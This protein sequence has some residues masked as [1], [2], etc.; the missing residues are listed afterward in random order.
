MGGWW[1]QTRGGGGQQSPS[2]SH[3]ER[4]RGG[5]GQKTRHRGGGCQTKV[6]AAKKGVQRG[7][8]PCCIAMYLQFN[9]NKV[10]TRK[11]EC[12]LYAHTSRRRVDHQGWLS[13]VV[14]MSL[15]VVDGH[16]LIC[17]LVM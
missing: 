9:V 2:V 7:F 3:F 16:S 15:L 8:V 17:Q 12:T 10:N 14:D 1:C 4:G 5:G 13:L 6:V 11:D